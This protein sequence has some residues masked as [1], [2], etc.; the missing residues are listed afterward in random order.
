[1]IYIVIL[2][3]LIGALIGWGTNSLAI[4]LLFHPRKSIKF[5]FWNIYG[6][7]PKRQDEIAQKIA[8]VVANELLSDPLVEI[9]VRKKEIIDYIINQITAELVDKI[10]E[11]PFLAFAGLLVKGNTISGAVST[12]RNKLDDLLENL[13]HKVSENIDIERQICDKVANYKISQL[14]KVI[15]DVSSKELKRIEI[16]GGI[17]GFIIGLVQALFVALV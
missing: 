2:M 7:I 4:W 11:K 14:E 13:A 6:L 17:L 16:L 5:L 15:K 9:K 1:M 10:K 8:E 12:L 3:P